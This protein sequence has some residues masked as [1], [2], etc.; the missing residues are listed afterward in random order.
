MML[1]KICPGFPEHQMLTKLLT[2]KIRICT[3]AVLHVVVS[4]I[5]LQNNR[6][7]GVKSSQHK[8]TNYINCHVVIF[9]LDINILDIT[10]L[11]FHMNN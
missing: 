8:Y 2:L 3:G 11:L 10:T 4:H 7:L 1:S 6:L 9:S 5:Y